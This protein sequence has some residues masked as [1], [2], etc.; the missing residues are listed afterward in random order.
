MNFTLRQ[1][2]YFIAA[3]QTG[4]ITMASKRANI[5]PPAISTAITQLEREL[6]AQLFLRHHARGLSLTPAGR[7][8][9]REATQLLKQADGLYSA[10]AD[11]VHQVRGELSVGWFSTLAPVVMPE[12][13]QSFLTANAATRIRSV[14]SDQQ[15]LMERLRRA[16]CEIAITYDLQIGSDIEFTPLATL[17]PYA[18]LAASHRLARARSVSLAQLSHLPLVLL[19]MP[20]SREYFMAM[21]QREGLEPLV[22]WT[23]TQIDVVRSLVA[24][25]LGYTLLNVRPRADVA[26]DG[27]RVVRVP[28]SG[29]AP[30]LTLGTAALKQLR[31]TRLVDAF[32]RH[33]RALITDSYIPGMAGKSVPG[34]RRRS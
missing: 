18:L 9:L 21:F 6:D 4:S 15:G 24:N 7:G 30:A 3:A 11:S 28:L 10:A 22:T 32:E 17:P 27:R 34:R 26:L 12:T 5:S 14:E 29:E 2:Q 31:R 33:C 16:E 13:V 25:G 23:S 1:L 19:D 8:L 20:L